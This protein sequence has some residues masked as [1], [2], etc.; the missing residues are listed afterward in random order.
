MENANFVMGIILILLL[1]T[2]IIIQFFINSV[3]RK[4]ITELQEELY[5]QTEDNTANDNSSL[6]HK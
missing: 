3:Y 2:V 6:R 1:S 5:N 4:R